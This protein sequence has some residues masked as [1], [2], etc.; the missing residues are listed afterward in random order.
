MNVIKWCFNI[1][2]LSLYLI[3]SAT[4]L[5]AET[6][7]KAKNTNTKKTANLKKTERI[8]TKVKNKESG[9]NVSY[10]IKKGDTIKKIA[11]IK[12]VA[13]KDIISLNK[14]INPKMLKPGQV[15]LI[16]QRSSLAK[17]RNNSKRN[18]DVRPTKKYTLARQEM[19][20]L[21]NLKNNSSA[22]ANIQDDDFDGDED[23]SS[24]TFSDFEPKKDVYLYSLRD[25]DLKRLINSALD[26]IGASYKYGGD[27]IASIDCSA[28]VRR[29]FK[30]VN[31]NLP[32]TSREQYTLG[33]E[34][35]FEELKE[36][37]LI[38]FAKKNRINHVGIYIGNNMYIHAARKDKGV[39]VSSLDSVYVKRYFV[40]AK[41]LFTLQSASNDNIL[42]E[43]LVN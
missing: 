3:F 10:K 1:L 12:G 18:V 22:T 11:K 16:P 2:I 41:R 35:S 20:N 32:R 21:E 8:K 25:D 4:N 23:I 42:K 17:E 39:I 13:E 31:I 19:Q 15:I 34:V 7:T 30:E 36:G 43:K 28:F 27:S 9:C 40:G 33:T 14:D 26:Y 29:V 38:F 24:D 37:D 5:Q 6:T